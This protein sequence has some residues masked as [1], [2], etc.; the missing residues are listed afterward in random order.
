[1][2]LDLDVVPLPQ[3]DCSSEKV[4]RYAKG[5]NNVLG[6]PGAGPIMVERTS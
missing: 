2:L 3:G 1:M 4:L 6:L 5:K